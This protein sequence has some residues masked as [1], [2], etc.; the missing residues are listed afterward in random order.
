[1]ATIEDALRDVVGPSC[2]VAD[3]DSTQLSE[4]LIA[5]SVDETLLDL[6]GRRV[7]GAIYDCLEEDC[8]IPR[9]DIPARLDEFFQVMERTFGQEVGKMIA[10]EFW[11]K[12][13]VK[14]NTQ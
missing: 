1:M 6:V 5:E 11:F 8:E 14:S 2:L 3:I 10:R 9:S 12:L 4:V 7:R 13:G